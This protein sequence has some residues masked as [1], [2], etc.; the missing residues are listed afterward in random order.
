M[1]DETLAYLE[2]RGS[3]ASFSYEALW[4]DRTENT[5]EHNRNTIDS[6]WRCLENLR[7]MHVFLLP[8]PLVHRQC[9]SSWWTT[10]AVTIPM[11]Q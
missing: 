9:R 3:A 11:Q 1:L 8:S 6:A 5:V 10:E 7:R 4:K 2:S